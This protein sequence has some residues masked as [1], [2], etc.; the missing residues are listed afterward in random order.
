MST[1]FAKI[2]Q[3]RYLSGIVAG[4]A[5]AAPKGSLSATPRNGSCVGYIAA[6]PIPEVQR[7][8]NAF[9]KGC[10]SRFAGCTVKV[11]WL[12][13]WHSVKVEGA[14]ARYFW[15]V[16]Q[17][18]I[19]TQHSDTT[20]PQLVYKAYGGLGVGYNSGIPNT[21]HRAQTQSL[22]LPHR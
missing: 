3:M 4:D 5:L 19:I 22:D 7:G 11:L 10:R 6:Y 16:A 15:N 8:I 2:Y 1:A 9:A 18:D 12:G 13:T 14:A 20:E 17:C 21:C